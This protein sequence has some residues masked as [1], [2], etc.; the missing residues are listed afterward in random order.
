[1]EA[2]LKTRQQAKHLRKT[3]TRPEV[4]LWINLKGRG[5]EGLK[6]R[7]QHPLGPYI[8]DFYCCAA[9]LCVEVDGAGHGFGNRPRKD[10]FRDAWLKSVGVR[11]LRLSAATILDDADVAL[12][13]ILAAAGRES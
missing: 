4:V 3:M 9:R 6:F 8:L 5:L 11:T 12:R 2:P 10:Q 7:R 13:M 1:M